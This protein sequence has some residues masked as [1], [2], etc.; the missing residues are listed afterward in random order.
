[1]NRLSDRIA[2]KYIL[3]YIVIEA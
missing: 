2:E 3:Y 1:M